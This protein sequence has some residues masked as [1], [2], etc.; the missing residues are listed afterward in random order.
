MRIAHSHG[1]IG[2]A[3]DSLQGEDVAAVLDEVASEGM[4]RRVCGLALR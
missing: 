4:T 1:Q 2:M 3:Q